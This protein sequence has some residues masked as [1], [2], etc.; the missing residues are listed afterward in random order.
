M[1]ELIGEDFDYVVTVCDNAAESC[2]LFP[3]APKRIHWSIP[4]PAAVEGSEEVRAAAF[5][6]AADELTSRIRQ[7]LALLAKQG[8]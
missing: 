1:D 5:K 6:R 8:S 2:P 7:L 4:D 3:G